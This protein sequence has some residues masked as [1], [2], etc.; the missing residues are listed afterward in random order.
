MAQLNELKRMQQLAGLITE[1]QLNEEVKS[2]DQALDNSKVQAAGEKLAQ[3]SALL[4]KGIDQLSKLGIDKN[5][6]IKAAQ[7][8]SSGK[9]VGNIVDDKIEIAT[10]KVNELSGS[11]DA[12][13]LMAG[14]GAVLGGLSIAGGGLPLLVGA[15][16][17][18]LAGAGAATIGGM[19]D[20]KSQQQESIEQAVNEA[21]AKFRRTGK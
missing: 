18:G 19:K 2:V 17:L 14:L 8:H 4:Q 10:E 20:Y 16:I 21:L 6:L 11:K 5:I 12:G 15:V 9:D 7:A 1:S 13:N 3:D